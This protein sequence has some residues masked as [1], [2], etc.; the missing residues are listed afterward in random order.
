MSHGQAKRSERVI[1]GE[2][3]F[4]LPLVSPGEELRGFGKAGPPFPVADH[5]EGPWHHLVLRPVSYRGKRERGSDVEIGDIQRIL[6]NKVAPRL[7]NIAHQLGKDLIRQIGLRNFNAQQRPIIGI[8]RCFPQLLGI[9][10][11]KAFIAGN[12]KALAPGGQNAVQQ[13][14]RP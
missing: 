4:T 5:A 10:F 6:L 8:K 7:H 1:R 12:R 9:H 3:R 13:F 14:R 2:A 11:A